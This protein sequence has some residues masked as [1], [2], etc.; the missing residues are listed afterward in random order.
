MSTVRGVS[1]NLKL[2]KNWVSRHVSLR[3]LLL[4][5]SVLAF[6]VAIIVLI[7]KT[8][9][10][11]L[12]LI[13]EWFIAMQAF[14]AIAYGLFSGSMRWLPSLHVI[15]IKL[16]ILANYAYVCFVLIALIGFSFDISYWGMAY[17]MIEALGI[18]LLAK[19]ESGSLNQYIKAQLLV[20]K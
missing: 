17:L 7:F 4:I 1:H 16:L 8:Y 18:F 3:L 13:P 12:F 2:Y 11:N 10:S 6:S 19:A 20:N 15:P 9:L 5:D 14:I